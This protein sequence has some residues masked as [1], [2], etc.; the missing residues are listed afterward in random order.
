MDWAKESL[1]IMKVDL[2]ILSMP[3]RE[4]VFHLAGMGG[5]IIFAFLFKKRKQMLSG[6]L[7]SRQRSGLPASRFIRPGRTCREHLGAKTN[8]WS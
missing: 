2:F 8:L 5:K 6:P 1:K 4:C 7:A 3:K